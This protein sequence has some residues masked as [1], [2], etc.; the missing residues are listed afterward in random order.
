MPH[1]PFIRTLRSQWLGLRLREI[2]E[3][4]ELSLAMVAE[5]LNRDRSALGRYERAEWPIQ[6]HDMQALLDIYGFHKAVERDQMLNLTDEIWR[7]GRWVDSDRDSPDASFLNIPWLESRAAQICSYHAS[8][9]P[10]LF[11]LPEYAEQVIRCVEGPEVAEA[12]VGRAIA[13][14]MDRQKLL[15]EPGKTTFETIIDESALRRQIGGPAL[16]RAQ[17]AHVSKIAQRPH[18]EIRVLP[19]R[20]WLHPGIDGSFWL[21][22]MPSPYPAVAYQENLSG[23]MYVEAPK[24]D[25][26]LRAYDRMRE[27]ALSPSESATLIAS[28]GE[29]LS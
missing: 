15:D 13:L 10:G 26:F 8:L 1:K 3:E 12:T 7:T 24:S 28:I 17:L 20:V 2:R 4:R 18:V 5:Y 16:L 29:E 21:F 23:Q 9:I 22:R 25:R 6:R 19:A 11:Q 14:R 27:A